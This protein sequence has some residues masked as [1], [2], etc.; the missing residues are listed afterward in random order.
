MIWLLLVAC[1]TPTQP[2]APP[3]PVP[4]VV[5][6]GPTSGPATTVSSPTT[7]TSV[8][9]ECPRIGPDRPDITVGPMFVCERTADGR[10]VFGGQVVHRSNATTAEDAVLAWVAGPTD[11]E[12]AAGLQGW[13]LRPYPWFAD[14]LTFRREGTTLVMEV[15]QWEPINNLSTSNG[16]SVFY[17][18]LFGTVFS[19]PTVEEFILSILGHSC[20]VMI[21]ESEWCFPIDWD[22][23]ADS[24]G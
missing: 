1:V 10:P 18:T 5:P 2:T 22:D 4:L 15:G 3:R 19:D 6:D 20:P 9:A 21:G 12:Q 7:M 11:R 17:T 16:S 23:F 14:S 24:L 13:D 8:A